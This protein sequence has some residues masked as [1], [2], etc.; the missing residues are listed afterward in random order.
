VLLVDKHS[1]TQ[2]Q[3]CPQDKNT[4]RQ[5]NVI[6][7]LYRY[8]YY[9]YFGIC[10]DR[11]VLSWM[12]HKEQP[13][14]SRYG[15]LAE[16]NGFFAE[17]LYN[18]FKSSS[19]SPLQGSKHQEEEPDSMISFPMEKAGVLA[20]Q[21]LLSEIMSFGDSSSKER[22]K[23]G[24]KHQE[25]EE[26]RDTI[27]RQMET[28]G[29]LALQ[30]LLSEI[31]SFGDSSSK[32]RKKPGNK[33]QEEEEERDTICRQMETVGVLALQKFLRG[34][35]D[36]DYSDTSRWKKGI[37]MERAGVRA[38]KKLLEEIMT[39]GVSSLKKR[40]KR[41]NERLENVKGSKRAKL[42]ETVVSRKR[43]RV[44]T[45]FFRS[46][47]EERRKEKQTQRD[48]LPKPTPISKVRRKPKDV[49]LKKRT[50][51]GKSRP[52]NETVGSRKR[53]RVATDFFRSSQEERREEKPTQRGGLPKPTP[54]SKVRRT[55]KDV[56]LKKRTN[57]C[58]S[59]LENETV[60]SRR[61]IRVAT[62]FFRPSQE[63][64]REENPTQRDGP[65]EPTAVVEVRRTPKD[66]SLKKR[67]KDGNGHQENEKGSQRAKLCETV[68]S[69]KR[70]RVVTDFFRPS[71]ERREENPTQRDGPPEST[72]VV[73]VRRTP[74]DV[75]LKKRTK[76][77]NGH[78]ENE[79][80]SQRAKLFE[81]VV[82]RKRIR[83]ATDFFRPSQEERWEEKP[84]QRDGPPEPTPVLEVHRT[85]KDVNR[86]QENDK[87]SKRAKPCETVVSRR[88][89]IRVTTDFFRP[90]QFVVHCKDV[91]SVQ[92]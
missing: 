80:G 70:I 55:P 2:K 47:Q 18:I 11:I 59:R 46:S 85:P 61:R 78:Q 63:E 49:S 76:R 58:K 5:T 20:L 81:T 31:M 13:S 66:V 73:E 28:V 79:K 72:P 40:K 6:T 50:N 15:E 54:V 14:D 41:G 8:L 27:F 89:R 88:G 64:R 4:R 62:D 84:T 51:R 38:L 3:R 12:D 34:V 42:C 48:R 10:I 74:K 67:K 87:G 60:V 39:F 32:E 19:E 77:G 53:I 1:L 71:Q 45:D 52:E 90:P 91:S 9:S 86:H 36:F 26:E 69:R 23:P 68:V 7:T 21:N 33:H 17:T 83:V 22:K 65:P 35:M 16:N 44:A 29:V 37:K 92:R 25:E 30:N 57:R 75:S 43:T 56:S 82:S 24:N